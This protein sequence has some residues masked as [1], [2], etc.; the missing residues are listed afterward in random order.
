MSVAFSCGSERW[1]VV[2]LHQA[3]RFAG[4]VHV[5]A[6]V[7]LL[8]GGNRFE[9]L[10]E[11]DFV[12]QIL[13]QFAQRKH[14]VGLQLLGADVVGYGGASIG[15]ENAGLVDVGVEDF[16]GLSEATTNCCTSV[17]ETAWLSA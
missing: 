10:V 13:D 9:L 5:I 2:L 8:V 7:G 3:D 14:G 1:V 6:D 11:S 12:A 17:V 15:S 16:P 4:H